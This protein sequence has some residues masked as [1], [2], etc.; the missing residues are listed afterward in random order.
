MFLMTYDNKTLEY[1]CRPAK[2]WVNDPNGLC[3]YGG[4][5][6][7]FYQHA[8]EAIRPWREPIS[9]GHSRT[10]D[11]LH[12]EELPEAL[13]PGDCGEYDSF[14]CWSGTACEKN[15]V[16]YLYYASVKLL[17]NGD[18]VQTISVAY[19]R[20]GVNFEKHPG[21]PVIDR[22]P[23]EGCRDFRDPAVLAEGEKNWLVIASANE[24]HT[25]GRLLLYE[26]A[27]MLAWEYRGVL[28]EYPGCKYCECPSFLRLAD[29][30]YLLAC[31]V[32]ENGTGAKHFY[33]QV[34]AFDG[35]NFVPELRAEPQKGPD[36]YTGQVFADKR[37]RI[38]LVS[39]IPGWKYA[40][41]FEHCVGCM[42]L[43]MQV[44]IDGGIKLFPPEECAPLLCG[45]DPALERRENGF[46]IRRERE[47]DIVCDCEIKDIKL[48]RD[49]YILEVF[50]NGGERVYTAMLV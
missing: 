6:H 8:R 4:Y 39:W 33:I 16:L 2:G 36:Q 25:V 41:T 35:R 48:L 23:A 5:Y 19:S 3:E 31:S 18:D 32:E 42:S 27:D 38:M 26:S 14:G 13:I 17:P 11:Y 1:H 10:K 34:G 29:G 9:W 50:V 47:P 43:P 46:A 37:G 7:V 40:H 30:R 45:T 44:C 24:E 49:G 20:D 22:F 15:G 12:F 21:N 28:A